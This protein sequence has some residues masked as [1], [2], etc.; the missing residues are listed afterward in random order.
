MKH[1]KIAM[2][3]LVGVFLLS[4][5][6]PKEPTGTGNK[7]QAEATDGPED[8]TLDLAF[9]KM[10]GTYEGELKD[11][12][13]NGKGVFTSANTDQQSWSYEG[14]FVDGHFQGSGKTVWQSG[15]T[16]TGHYENDIWQPTTTEYYQFIDTLPDSAYTMTEEAVATITEHEDLFPAESEEK[17]KELLNTEAAFDAVLADAASYGDKLVQVPRAFVIKKSSFAVTENPQNLESLRCTYLVLRTI[18]GETYEVYY[19]GNLDEIEKETW[20]SGAYGLPMGT[21]VLEGANTVILAGSFV[22]KQIIGMKKRDA[23]SVRISFYFR[24][25]VG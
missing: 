6:S 20:I 3:V 19:R 10:E 22:V 9:G 21:A 25:K 17:A 13:P 8:M 4:A 15:Q 5:C 14:E 2:C 12:V 11:G 16:Q 23:V 7:T 24:E 1:L 18:D